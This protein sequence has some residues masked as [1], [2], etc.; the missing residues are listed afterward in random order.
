MTYTSIRQ[1]LV[2]RGG[3]NTASGGLYRTRQ[4]L[5]AYT[6]SGGLQHLE[7]YTASGGLQYLE[8]YTASGQRLLAYSIWWS[9]ARPPPT[10]DQTGP[11]LRCLGPTP[12]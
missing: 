1:H 9:T 12:T 10:V 7:I 8:A 3:G 4:H 5:K 6:A 11:A 2:A